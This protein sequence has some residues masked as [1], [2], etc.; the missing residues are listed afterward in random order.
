MPKTLYYYFQMQKKKIQ[1][2]NST[3]IKIESIKLISKRER[4][5]RKKE[6]QQTNESVDRQANLEGLKRKKRKIKLTTL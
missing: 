5:G 2:Y 3:I 4:E 6:K 1:K